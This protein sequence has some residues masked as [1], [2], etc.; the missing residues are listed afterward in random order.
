MSLTDYGLG[1]IVSLKYLHTLIINGIDTLNGSGL[2]LMTKFGLKRLECQGC[3]C[4]VNEPLCYILQNCLQL[5]L[6][7]IAGCRKINNRVVK[8][9]IRVAQQKTNHVVLN[10]IIHKDLISDKDA[11]TIPP[12]LQLLLVDYWLFSLD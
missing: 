5:E 7:D 2:M 8:T 1:A 12:L 9:A 4:I 6:L 3:R 11:T 10:L